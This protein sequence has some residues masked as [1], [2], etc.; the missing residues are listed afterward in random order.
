MKYWIALVFSTHAWSQCLQP[1]DLVAQLPDWPQTSSVLDFTTVVNQFGPCSIGGDLGP[2]P[3]GGFQ[4][5]TT[6]E[7]TNDLSVSRDEVAFSG[8]PIPQSLNLLDTSRLVLIRDSHWHA[9]QFEVISRWG[10][11]VDNAALPV[12]WLQ[13]AAPVELEP[14][15]NAL[16]ELRYYDAPPVPDDPYA[17]SVSAMGDI[18][19]VD[20]GL[21]TFELDS[22]NP[23]L[24][25]G[26][27][28]DMDQDGIGR[29]SIYNHSP[30]AGPALT[31][32][33]GVTA[34]QLSTATPGQ[35]VVDR[36]ELV[37]SGPVKAVVLMEGHFSAPGGASL[38]TIP[39]GSYERFE[40]SYALTMTR[41]SRD[42]GIQYHIRNTCSS[43]NGEPWT[44]EAST[45][46]LAS[47]EFPFATLGNLTTYF[48]GDQLQSSAA[49]F[50]GVTTVAQPKGSGTPWLRNAMTALDAAPQQSAEF[51]QAPMLAASDGNLVIGAQIPW[52]RFREP[53]AMVMSDHQL[54]LRFISEPLIVGEGKGIWNFAHLKIQPV[55]LF[56]QLG[57]IIDDLEPLRQSGMARLERGL[58]FHAPV[59]HTNQANLLPSLGDQSTSTLKTAYLNLLTG[60]HDETVLPGGQW[61]RAQTFG[62]Q[63][64]P[65]VQTDAFFEEDPNTGPE[66]TNGAMNYW[67]PSGAELTEFLRSGDPRWVWDFAMQQSWLQM[68]TAYLNVGRQD[69]SFQNG[70]AIRSGGVG[71]GQWHRSGFGSVDY[72]YSMGMQFA[73]ALRPNPILR[74]RF[75]QAGR[76]LFNRYSV[77]KE[78]EEMRTEFF[79]QVNITRGVIQHFE[80]LANAAEFAPGTHGANSHA[81]LLEVVEELATDNMRA[82]IMCQGDVPTPGNCGQPQQF[83]QSA[84]MYHFFHRY[85]RNYGDVANL[86]QTLI[87]APQVYYQQG[88]AKLGDGVSIDANGNWAALLDCPLT[89][90]D[91]TVGTC[92]WVATNDGPN[93]LSHNKFQTASLLLMA[94][95]LE[96]GIGSC[97]LVKAIMDDASLIN[98][99]L[100]PH[101][102]QAG[103]WKGVDQAVQGG[104]FGIGLYDTCED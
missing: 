24:I 9:A 93:L 94:H 4:T 69:H 17:V 65:D 75:A 36:F 91:T 6:L 26:I 55:A 15:S 27:S 29:T 32:H 96:P 2:P 66:N 18:L 31:F 88:M 64:W 47:L 76:T 50:T 92:T 62:S 35:V 5:I 41:A 82:G 38:C 40:F 71:E 102:N 57:T 49:N 19:M 42:L 97:E 72:S 68:Y 14:N 98:M 11:V 77:P 79:N 80:M 52:M 85:L 89:N 54:S 104:I 61:D 67:N 43:G 33:D 44:D 78:D 63:L 87:A 99:W 83:M 70:V 16:F 8:V 30:G 73:Y 10:G 84:L 60:F 53:Q 101:F 20:T 90:G 59:S 58:L 81:R 45:I 74:H 86:R 23:A 95:E 56:D 48:A 100:D 13:V 51:F 37:E 28:I 34:H 12:R 46:E 25:T 103:W 3:P 1:S 7:V 21:A 22:T 39:G